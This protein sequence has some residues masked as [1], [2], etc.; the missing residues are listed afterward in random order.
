M[1][2]AVDSQSVEGGDGGFSGHS[3]L[4]LLS[5]PGRYS[6]IHLFA[7]SFLF[8]QKY[9]LV[10]ALSPTLFKGTLSGIKDVPCIWF[11]GEHDC[12]GLCSEWVV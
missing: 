4:Q 7:L 5:G 11:A 9:F 3:L 10:S 12:Q 8:A 6:G 1:W 2:D